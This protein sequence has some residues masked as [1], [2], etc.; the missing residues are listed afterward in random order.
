M[1]NKQTKAPVS[2]NKKVTT[3]AVTGNM[4][5]TIV[6]DW[7]P[8]LNSRWADPNYKNT[9]WYRR[10]TAA[11]QART[12]TMKD[13]ENYQEQIRQIAEANKGKGVGSHV[14]ELT[15]ETKNETGADVDQDDAMEE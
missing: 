13:Y 9:E 3:I 14:G 5:S 4:G 1:A 12:N 6:N 10:S 2:T 11:K 8:D 7:K 15:G